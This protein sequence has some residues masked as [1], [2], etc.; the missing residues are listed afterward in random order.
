MESILLYQFHTDIINLNF[1]DCCSIQKENNNTL[2]GYILAVFSKVAIDSDL[3]SHN[4]AVNQINKISV[5]LS[6]ISKKK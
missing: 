1:Y 6:L 5:W 4:S 2:Q 3:W